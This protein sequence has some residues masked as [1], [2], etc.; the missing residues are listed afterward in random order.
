MEGVPD[1]YVRRRDSVGV[2]REQLVWLLLCGLVLFFAIPEGAQA[3]VL[4]QN[5]AVGPGSEWIYNSNLGTA[6][7]EILDREYIDGQWFYRWRLSVAGLT[8]EEKLRLTDNQLSVVD[9]LFTAFR[10]Y[11][12]FF[13]FPEDELTL[14]MPLKVGSTWEWEGPVTHGGH[15]GV[16]RVSGRVVQIVQVEVPAGKFTTYEI[17]LDRTDDFGTQQHIRLWLEAEIGVV[18]AEGQLQWQGLVGKMQNLVGFNHFA[19]ELR[20]YK[21]V[22]PEEDTK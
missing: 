2:L 7:S 9:R 14:Q 15:T 20:S 13:A 18:R 19:V 4:P 3:F 11:H 8:Y 21:I 10:L 22:S 5:S 1:A 12:D 6:H 16:D 17:E